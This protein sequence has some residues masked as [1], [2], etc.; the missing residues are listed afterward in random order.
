MGVKKVPTATIRK[1]KGPK[2]TP[3][4]SST[5]GIVAKGGKR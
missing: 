2:V 5:Y 4:L 3:N 1:G